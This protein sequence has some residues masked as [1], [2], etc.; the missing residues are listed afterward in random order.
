MELAERFN[1]ARIVFYPEDF[2]VIELVLKGMGKI[3]IK[4]ELPMPEPEPDPMP[5]EPV[6]EVS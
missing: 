1:G 4:S 3:H 6:E 2:A 5:P